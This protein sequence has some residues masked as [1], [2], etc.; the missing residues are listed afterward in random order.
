[1]HNEEFHSLY[2]SPNIAKVMKYRRLRWGIY[3]VRMEEARIASKISTDKPTGKRSSR[4][5][6][7]RWEEK[8]RM[9]LKE[10]CLSTRNGVDLAQD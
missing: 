5:P 10:I 3:V 8:I 1:L 7:R 6:R 4:K 2:L 9:Y